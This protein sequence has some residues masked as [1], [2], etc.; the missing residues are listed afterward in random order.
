MSRRRWL[1]YDDE[2]AVQESGMNLDDDLDGM[3]GKKG[4]K[5]SGYLSWLWDRAKMQIADLLLLLLC[6]ASSS[7]ISLDTLD[8]PELIV[9]YVLTVPM[10]VEVRL[11]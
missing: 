1:G 5:G 6:S 2:A 11:G 7:T 10:V 8:R 4:K 9:S 3:V